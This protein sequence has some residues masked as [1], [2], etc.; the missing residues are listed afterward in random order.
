MK[1]SSVSRLGHDTMDA[2]ILPIGGARAPK[3]NLTNAKYLMGDVYDAPYG[4]PS[5][6]GDP[7]FSGDP[8]PYGD[9]NMANSA[10]ANYDVMIGDMIETGGF[11]PAHIWQSLP[12]AVKLLLGGVGAAGATFGTVK[13]VQ[14]ILKAHQRNRARK[15]NLAN[16]QYNSR[17]AGTI[18]NTLYSRQNLAKIHPSQLTSFYQAQGCSLGAY[19]IS[20]KK[21]FPYKSLTWTF[22]QQ[23]NT[24]PFVAQIVNSTQPGGPGTDYIID[25]A[26]PA[27]GAYYPCVFIVIGG[28]ILQSSPGINFNVTAT[29]PLVNGTLSISAEPF[30]FTLGGEYYAKICIF[31][32]TL[33]AAEP[34]YTSGFYSAAN[35]INIHVSGSIPNPAAVSAVVPGTM[36]QWTIGMRNAGI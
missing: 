2:R 30:T 9:P 13:G 19:P 25:I 22:D 10:L 31:P 18:H 1:T 20:P 5:F 36:H 14:A 29:L 15:Q 7:S 12:K 4:D 24:S 28:N 23:S 35:H 32:W 6:R 27:N 33:V 21:A 11:S 3:A 17:N 16:A 8:A 26:G 34:V